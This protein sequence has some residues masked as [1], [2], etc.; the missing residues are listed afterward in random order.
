MTKN[1]SVDIKIEYLKSDI[2]EVKSDIKYI[3]SEFLTRREFI[4]IFD[5]VKKVVYGLVS[6]IL[7]SVV[8]AVISLIIIKQ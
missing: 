8:G 6:L 2:E 1:G 7:I 4:D 3:K 5:P